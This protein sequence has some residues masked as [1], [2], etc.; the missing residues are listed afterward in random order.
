MSNKE[1]VICE[2]KVTGYSAKAIFVVALDEVNDDGTL[3]KGAVEHCI[4]KSQIMDGSE[5]EGKGDEGEL[6]IPKWLA[7]DRGL[8]DF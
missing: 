7:L 3:Q 4:P 8:T 1:E 6:V 2:V 5:V